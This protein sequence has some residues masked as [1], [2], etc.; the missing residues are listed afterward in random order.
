MQL[1]NLHR[2]RSE[3]RGNSTPSGPPQPWRGIKT[4]RE[5]E[6]KMKEIKNHYF[7]LSH[8]ER[9][10]LISGLPL[11]DPEGGPYRFVRCSIHPRLWS[12]IRQLYPN[13]QFVETY[14]GPEGR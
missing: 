8:N 5:E 14:V 2:V 3:E 7:K 12:A 11:P 1:S 9:T 6:K 4:P 13:S 10:T